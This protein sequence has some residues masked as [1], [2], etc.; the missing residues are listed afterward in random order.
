M[1]FA[2]QATSGTGGRRWSLSRQVLLGF[3]VAALIIGFLFG[4]LERWLETSELQQ[5]LHE[6]SRQTAALLAAVSVDAMITEDQPLLETIIEQVVGSN[7][8]IH[9][10]AFENEDGASLARFVRDP[11][12]DSAS[13]LTLSDDIVFKGEKFGRLIIEWDVRPAY[14]QIEAHV[15]KTRLN[16]IVSLSVVLLIFTALIDWL[17]LRPIK[18]ILSRLTELTEGNLR[19]D[20]LLPRYAAREFAQLGD[21]VNLLAG[22]WQAREEGRAQLHD[23]EA[24]YDAVIRGAID[25]IITMD[26]GGLISSFN[27]AAEKIFGCVA[28]EAMGK[29]FDS[30]MPEAHGDLATGGA[31]I[32]GSVREVTGLR[33][34]GTTFPMELA[35]REIQLRDRRMFVGTV[36]DVTER[37]SVREM[38]DY[39]RRQN[40]LILN[41]A[42]EGIYGLD[43]RGRATFVNPAAARMT[44]WDVA[45]LIGEP[46]HDILH[47]SRHDGSPYPKDE[48]P[49]YA[50][51]K[52]GEA[53]HVTGEVIWRKDG[54]NFPVEYVSTPIREND[55][56][57]GAVVVFRDITER[58]SAEEALHLAK[59]QAEAAN[60]SKAEFLAVMSHEI[61]TPLNGVLG[62]LGLLQDMELGDEQG[63]YVSSARSSAE[64][65][66]E[67]INDVLDFSKIEAGKLQFE[68]TGFS[69]HDLVD[70]VVEVLTPRAQT[71]G[72][73]L[74]AG[75]ASDAPRYLLGDPGRI[76]QV[77]L[78]LAENAVKFT[79][80]G[81]ISIAVTGVET[82][83]GRA[84]LHFEVADT[85]IGIEQSRKDELF[86]PFSTLDP[87]YARKFGGTGLGLAICKRL[88]E[89]MGGEIAYSSVSGEGSRFWFDV[90][91]GT[92]TPEA[93][94]PA[95]SESFAKGRTAG[96][97]ARILL[98]ED[99][100]TNSLVAKVL[101]ERAGHKV[102]MVGNG[103]EAVEAVRRFPYDFVLMDVSMPEMDGLEATAAIRSLPGGKADIPIVALTAYA[104]KGDRERFLAAGMDDY[105]TKPATREDMLEVIERWT[106]KGADRKA[107]VLAKIERETDPNLDLAALARLA[108]DTDPA[109]MPDLIRSFLA[110]AGARRDKIFEAT[111]RQDFRTLG[112]ETHTLG[113]SA[114]TFGAHLVH[115][116]A[117]EVEAA[118]RQEDRARA[119]RLAETLP[120]TIGASIDALKTYIR[121]ID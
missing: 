43:L 42:G 88:V 60:R 12:P 61:R 105:L 39:L 23:R 59:E 30:L 94:G 44:G 75:V 72:L 69:L 7:P 118:C 36:R 25:G 112:Y 68:E 51:F 110:D 31:N 80:E 38:L 66:L 119:L 1:K 104:M 29:N 85:G 15:Q 53:H 50:A 103:A 97:R 57:V 82:A 13:L 10:L 35:I 106:G 78:N 113:N 84:R 92:A 74:S 89:M 26:A 48:S 102:D 120:E 21:S 37:L 45:E 117:R 17:A 114:Y 46:Q 109:V 24:H 93:V 63:T 62:L 71:K 65:L 67:I 111:K 41:S 40:E 98:A 28:S 79:E 96:R 73:G 8:A 56:L 86:S 18:R 116:L 76:R 58:K 99:N 5:Q 81:G 115:E 87:S 121:N 55:E 14:R 49:I 107:A 52:D 20:F 54:S 32:L 6:Q 22:T 100:P 90:E 4:E 2:K 77:L 3:G 70:S 34:D 101:L 64:S 108:E 47:H 95:L 16:V 19:Q 83:Q 91:L 9:S 27:P 11:A 33:K